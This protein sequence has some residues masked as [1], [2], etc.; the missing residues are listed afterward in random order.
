[1]INDSPR[2]YQPRS[3]P[4]RHQI[5]LRLRTAMLH[6][7]QQ[8]RINP[9]QPSQRSGIPPIIFFPT[10]SDQAHVARMRHDHF[11]PQFTQ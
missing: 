11:M 5:R 9:H 7:R 6:R 3:R 4:D 10:L 2:P 8:L 1:L